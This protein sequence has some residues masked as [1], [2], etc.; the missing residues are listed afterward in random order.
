MKIR[1][2]VIHCPISSHFCSENKPTHHFLHFLALA[3]FFQD[4]EKTLHE[5]S[6]KEL[7]RC[8]FSRCWQFHPKKVVFLFPRVLGV[9]SLWVISQFMCFVPTDYS[10]LLIIIG[11][12]FPTDIKT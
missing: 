3:I 11:V 1:A 9:I 4:V 2:I 8:V 7:M 10:Q 12:F 5:A 6:C